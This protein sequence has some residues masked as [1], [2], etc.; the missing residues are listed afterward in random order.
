MP[1]TADAFC[2]AA[3]RLYLPR[4]ERRRNTALPGAAMPV[5][6]GPETCGPFGKQGS[7]PQLSK[8]TVEVNALVRRTTWQLS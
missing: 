3:P 2:A 4:H 1:K 7:R 5:D 6:A 8:Q